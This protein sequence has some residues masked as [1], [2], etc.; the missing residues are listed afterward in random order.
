[1]SNVTRKAT[2][3]RP[4]L[5]AKNDSGV[6]HNPKPSTERGKRRHEARVGDAKKHAE[7]VWAG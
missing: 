7:S 5:P 1:M 3:R 4:L 2:D 6:I